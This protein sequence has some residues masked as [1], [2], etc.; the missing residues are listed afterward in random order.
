MVGLVATVVNLIVLAPVVNL[1]LEAIVGSGIW[2]ENR[3][4]P[5]ESETSA[6][7]VTVASA[8]PLRLTRTIPSLR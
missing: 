4:S 6:I 1:G 8:V 3:K 5:F 2:R 7:F